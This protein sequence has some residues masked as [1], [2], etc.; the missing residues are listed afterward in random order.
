MGHKNIYPRVIIITQPE[1]P[2][3][4]VNDGA[5]A[6][7]IQDTINCLYDK[8][9]WTISV[10]DPK[11]DKT[12]IKNFHIH[13][14]QI[15][16]I[17]SKNE[18]SLFSPETEFELEYLPVLYR[19]Y[20][21]GIKEFYK[22]FA[23]DIMVVHTTRNGWLLALKY[24]L[25]DCIVVGYHHN[26]EDQITLPT[27]LNKLMRNIDAHIF[28]SNYSRVEFLRAVG[29]L[30]PLS[31]IQ[32]Y[33]VQNGV[34]KELFKNDNEL[35]SK[36]RVEYGIGLDKFVV[37]FVGRLIERKSPHRIIDAIRLLDPLQQENIVV[38]FAG[39]SDYLES[40]I[41]PYLEGLIQQGAQLISK[42]HFLGY[43][44]H[45]QMPDV[46]S[47]ADVLVM[48]S[49]GQEGLPLTVLEALACGIPVVASDVGGISEVLFD[50]KNGYL[51][52]PPGDPQ[53]IS[54]ALKNLYGR[55]TTCN[56]NLISADFSEQI[57]SKET[58][59]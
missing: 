54:L 57:N 28:V 3:P 22:I 5:I 37:L 10:W 21:L 55:F 9:I 26:S 1:Y 15:D 46:Y 59:A 29:L 12:T 36:T 7:V 44:K 25:M 4:A 31:R 27:I 33:S 24:E 51:I 20:L 52:T 38:I 13:A 53:E 48:P 2:V 8:P 11:L 45:E 35:R 47:M 41:T 56:G 43:I 42:V 39:G 30:D 16:R 34:D 50:E 58:M 23:A 19:Y 40:N 32:A 18:K 6:L 17:M 14:I 49:I